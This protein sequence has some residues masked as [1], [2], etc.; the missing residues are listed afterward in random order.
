VHSRSRAK[1]GL[2]YEPL[3]L[4]NS[5]L[6]IPRGECEFVT[7]TLNAEKLGAR[8]AIIMDDKEHGGS[9]VMADNGYG[10]VGFTQGTR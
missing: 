2:W 6:L 3:H 5:F 7:K 10:R 9:V 1:R 8:L 4:E